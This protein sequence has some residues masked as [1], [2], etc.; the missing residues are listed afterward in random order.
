MHSKNKA[1]EMLNIAY[2]VIQDMM[3]GGIT[4]HELVTSVTSAGALG[5][6]SLTA[7]YLSPIDVRTAIGKI[8]TLNR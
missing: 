6:C 1:C 5:S 8:R 2:P 4:I 7:E 3:A